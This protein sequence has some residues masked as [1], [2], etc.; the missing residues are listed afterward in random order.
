MI[1]HA[2]WIFLAI[3][4][5][6]YLGMWW[7]HI[8]RVIVYLPVSKKM[9]DAVMSSLGDPDIPQRFSTGNSREFFHHYYNPVKP[10]GPK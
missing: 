2:I 4:L 1:F 6:A 5:G 8:N 9:Q 7:K 10:V 3:C